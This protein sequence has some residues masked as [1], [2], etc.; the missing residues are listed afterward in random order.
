[1]LPES[2][3]LVLMPSLDSVTV[4]EMNGCLGV[5]LYMDI[6]VQPRLQLT[7]LPRTS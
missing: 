4:Q 5:L 3:E 2:V 7:R 1:M 6:T